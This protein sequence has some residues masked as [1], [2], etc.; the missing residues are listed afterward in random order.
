MTLITDKGVECQ[1]CRKVEYI[2]KTPRKQAKRHFEKQG[3]K[4]YRDGWMCKECHI[5]KIR[6][7]KGATT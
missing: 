3:W 7:V 5:I 4:L 2:L 6:R 1:I